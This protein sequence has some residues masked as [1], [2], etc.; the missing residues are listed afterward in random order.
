MVRIYIRHADKKYRNGKSEN[1]KHDPPIKDSAFTDA[2]KYGLHLFSLFGQPKYVF[3]SPF[4]RTRQTATAMVSK[5][6]RPVEIKCD[7]KLSEYLGHHAADNIDV[8][9]ETLKFNPPHPET[10]RDFEIRIQKHFDEFS[11]FDKTKDVCWFITH[12]LAICH[13]TKIIGKRINR[14]SPLGAVIIDSKVHYS[15]VPLM[16]KYY[17]LDDN[18]SGGES[19]DSRSS[20]QYNSE[21]I[22]SNDSVNIEDI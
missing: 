4:L 11:F 1:L 15:Y 17:K 3:C 14:I 8:T 22:L 7:P 20:D 16:N 6:P 2:E 5:L 10:L 21:A 13:L 19:S 18:S 9:S 12:G